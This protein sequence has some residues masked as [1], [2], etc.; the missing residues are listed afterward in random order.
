V[1]KEIIM[2]GQLELNFNGETVLVHFEQ[3]G[4]GWSWKSGRHEGHVY[5]LEQIPS[6][7][8]AATT[9]I[10]QPEAKPMSLATAIATKLGCD[11]EEVGEL[12]GR[13]APVQTGRFSAKKPNRSGGSV[14]L[15]QLKVDQRE[16]YKAQWLDL[17]PEE[18]E[19]AVRWVKEEWPTVI[20]LFR[21]N[22]LTADEKKFV[23]GWRHTSDPIIGSMVKIITRLCTP[24]GGVVMLP[25][26]VND[27]TE[28]VRLYPATKA[29]LDYSLGTPTFRT[30]EGRGF[31]ARLRSGVL[32]EEQLQRATQA[33]FCNHAN[34]APTT[35]PCSCPKHCYCKTAGGCGTKYE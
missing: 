14:T 33:V 27:I 8:L 26:E 16:K 2:K 12:L 1:L 4:T 7:V 18:F 9:T 32:A 21:R 19:M 5:S 23:D 24:Y 17:T 3:T 11:P 22:D 34:E 35:V 29:L 25:A 31:A 10:A 13:I 20:E 30:H 28:M 15:G 6:D